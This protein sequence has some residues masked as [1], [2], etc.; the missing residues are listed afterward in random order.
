[1]E[2]HSHESPYFEGFQRHTDQ[3][4]VKEGTDKEDNQGSGCFGVTELRD[5]DVQVTDA[6][7]K[8]GEIKGNWKF[9]TF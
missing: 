9:L 5:G 2:H 1:M 3:V 8:G 6:P 4:L 7:S